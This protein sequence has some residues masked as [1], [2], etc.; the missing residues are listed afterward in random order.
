MRFEEEPNNHCDKRNEGR[1]MIG[2]VQ[3]AALLTMCLGGTQ[4]RAVQHLSDRRKGSAVDNIFEKKHTPK[5]FK[6]LFE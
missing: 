5:K 4:E 1:I 3:D 2:Q 6:P